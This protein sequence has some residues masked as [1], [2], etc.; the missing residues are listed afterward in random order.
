MTEGYDTLD[1]D[2]RIPHIITRRITVADVVVTVLKD[3]PQD[4]FDFW[5]LSEKQVRQSLE[6]YLQDA[7]FDIDSVGD[8]DVEE[9]LEDI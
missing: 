9:Y 8:S 2:R 1:L 5:G 4:T 3:D 7:D 6:Y